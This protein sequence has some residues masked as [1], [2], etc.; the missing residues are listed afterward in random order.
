MNLGV[1]FE[2]LLDSMLTD[3]EAFSSVISAMV[4]TI[5]LGALLT[6]IYSLILTFLFYFVTYAIVVDDMSVI[7]AY[8]KSCSLLKQN[9]LKVFVFIVLILVSS[10]I[11][12]VV[13]IIITMPFQIIAIM[14]AF[15]FMF[16]PW[17]MLF[18]NLIV[19]VISSI[20]YLIFIAVVVMWSTRFYMSV[21]G[22]LCKEEKQEDLQIENI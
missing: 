8:K 5:L 19:S 1:T 3:P 16:N 10:V 21:T 11:W 17:V 20:V 9:F 15:A 22:Q 12:Y 2:G 13:S 4:T 14:I 18:S 7:K 6:F